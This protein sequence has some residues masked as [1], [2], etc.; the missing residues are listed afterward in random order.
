MGGLT[1]LLVAAAAF[2]IS[3]RVAATRGFI[4]NLE[5]DGAGLSRRV[6]TEPGTGAKTVEELE[7]EVVEERA[8]SL[9]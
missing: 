1:A 6:S 8:S 4:Q 2:V 7:E 5:F 9:K 3:Q